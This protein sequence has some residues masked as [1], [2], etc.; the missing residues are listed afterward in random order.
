MNTP[1]FNALDQKI[2]YLVTLCKKLKEENRQLRS[3]EQQL[4]AERAQLM[5][6]ND[7]ARKKVEAMI[8][9]LR[10]LEHES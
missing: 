5:E 8:S 2:E 4:R 6:Q 1:D 7:V 3:K 10:A 9:H